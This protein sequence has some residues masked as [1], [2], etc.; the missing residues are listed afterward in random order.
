MSEKK[1]SAWTK[2]DRDL[3]KAV[4]KLPKGDERKA[5]IEEVA[6]KLGRTYAA[7]EFQFY[8][9]KSIKKKTSKKASKKTIGQ[10]SYETRLRNQ[11]LGLTPKKKPKKR[12]Y[13]NS[14]KEEKKMGVSRNELRFP[15]KKISIEGGEVVVSF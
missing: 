5:A 6:A 9:G 14:P 1:G 4:G 8:K 3:L 15:Y 11:E 7:T 13:H 12:K 2:E 10:K